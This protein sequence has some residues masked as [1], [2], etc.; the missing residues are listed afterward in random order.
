L[1]PNY[2]TMTK[3]VLRCPSCSAILHYEKPRNWI[4]R[5][6]LFFIPLRVYF[7]AKCLKTKH[8]LITDKKLEAYHK[9]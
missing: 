6:I 4:G 1:Q 3:E 2:T 7:C 8:M 5:N 9:V